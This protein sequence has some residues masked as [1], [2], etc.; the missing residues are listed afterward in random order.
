VFLADY[1]LVLTPF[2]MR[3]LYP[4]DYDQRGFEQTQD[5]FR[6]AIY[7]VG[8]N[9]LSLPAGV[10]PIGLIEGLPAGVQII[11]ARY[12]EDLILDAMEAIEQRV[13]VLVHELWQRGL[14]PG[15]SDGA[16]NR[17]HDD[18]RS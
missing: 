10:V 12:R 15:N 3:P 5:I 1:P 2:M 13:G 18:A 16:A 14:D 11:G 9:Y 17:G 7:S 8:V 6:S 4:W